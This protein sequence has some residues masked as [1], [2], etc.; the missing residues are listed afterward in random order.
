MFIDARGLQPGQRIETAIC[1]IGANWI[2]SESTV[3][4]IPQEHTGNLISEKTLL[5]RVDSSPLSLL[6]QLDTFR[7][8]S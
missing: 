7:N 4:G 8:G 2:Y 1:I 6:N 3:Q 5:K